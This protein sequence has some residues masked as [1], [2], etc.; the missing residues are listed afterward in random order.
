MQISSVIPLVPDKD[1]KFPPRTSSRE[2]RRRQLAVSI[3]RLM[4]VAS[5]LASAWALFSSLLLS[6]NE[7]DQTF[8]NNEMKRTPRLPIKIIKQEITRNLA[9]KNDVSMRG[10]VCLCTGRRSWVEEWAEVS[11]KGFSVPQPQCDKLH[12]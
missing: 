3:K 6:S 11:A 8:L 5:Q 2:H 10:H 7:L 1:I 9:S 4:S 12:R